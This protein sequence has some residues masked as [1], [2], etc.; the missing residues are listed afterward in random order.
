VQFD[1]S[2][3]LMSFPTTLRFPLLSGNQAGPGLHCG[4]NVLI[5]HSVQD[6]SAVAMRSIIKTSHP[7]TAPSTI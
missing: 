3:L 5:T 2:L 1:R 6:E 4:L 7:T